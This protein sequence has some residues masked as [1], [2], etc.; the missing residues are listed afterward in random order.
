[1]EYGST[2]GAYVGRPRG[3]VEELRPDVQLDDEPV[4]FALCPLSH[5]YLRQGGWPY[6]IVRTRFSFPQSTK[7]QSTSHIHK[8]TPRQA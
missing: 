3:Y 7:I 2:E 6:A 4:L 1:M 8:T 5:Q